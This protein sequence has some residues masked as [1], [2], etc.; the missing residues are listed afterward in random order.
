MVKTMKK[1]KIFLIF[2]LA[3]YF[4][5]LVDSGYA[6]ST[7]Q[8]VRVKIFHDA[9]VFIVVIKGD[10]TVR[11]YKSDRIL[12]YG[13]KLKAKVAGYKGGILLAGRYLAANNIFIKPNGPEELIEINGRRFKGG[14]QVINRGGVILSLI[15]H[16]RLE[17]YVKGIAVRETSHYW[18]IE[19]LKA[20][21]V[22]FRTFALYRTEQFKN[23]EFDVSDDVFSQVYGGVEAERYRVTEAV[24]K[25]KGEVLQFEGKIL[26]AF[27]HSTCGGA[28]E[29]ADVL[30]DIDLAPLKGVACG[31]CKDSPHF[32]WKITLSKENIRQLWEKNGQKIKKINEVVIAGRD[33]SGRVNNLDI[34][35]DQK[36]IEI[37]AKDFRNMIGPDIIKSTNF[38]IIGSGS[39][40]TFEGFGW[41]HGVGLCQWGAYFMAK[42]GSDYLKI[43]DYYYPGSNLTK[44]GN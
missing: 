28:T 8:M 37:A 25:T 2:G 33:K 19:T 43:L 7:D 17:D 23:K 27:Y 39:D 9:P 26:P 3:L 20:E 40:L 16:L 41:G 22:V 15:N 21:A 44:L 5:F 6:Q 31:F 32:S 10:Y 29:D 30:W 18:P 42:Y 36:D 38:K 11:E 1:I 14:L 24:D 13:T 4:G 12:N 34:V 35:T